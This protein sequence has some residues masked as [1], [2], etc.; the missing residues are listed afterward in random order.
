M[1][2]DAAW[3]SL[4]HGMLP[5]RAR[6]RHTA[7]GPEPVDTEAGLRPTA[8]IM[9]QPWAD[10]E[11]V[12]GPIAA[13]GGQGGEATFEPGELPDDVE[14]AARLLLVQLAVTER[15]DAL[16]P[17]L[18]MLTRIDSKAMQLLVTLAGA[19]VLT[20]AGLL[21]LTLLGLMF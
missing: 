9:S 19:F 20:V 3:C 21:L 18:A 12:D 10:A 2:A 5:A 17:P 1:A 8:A 11:V 16:P 4:C 7:Q 6:G 14:A 13:F 15:A